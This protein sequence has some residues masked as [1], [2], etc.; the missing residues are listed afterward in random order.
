VL[1]AITGF[2]FF[3]CVSLELVVFHVLALDNLLLAILPL[4]GI[5][6][7]IVWAYWAPLGPRRPPPG[8]RARAAA[9]R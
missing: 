4:A 1:A 8:Y 5:V 9:D 7:G 2:F 3:L 6:L